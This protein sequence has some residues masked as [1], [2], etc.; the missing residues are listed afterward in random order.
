MKDLGQHF[1][2]KQ[3]IA[4]KIVQSINPS[5]DDIVL[6]IGGGKGILTEQIVDKV[7]KL[8]V[9]EIDKNLCKF[10][11]DK[12]KNNNNVEIINEDF[13]EVDL[14]RYSLY[15]KLKIV[16][17]IP[18]S[19]TSEILYKLYGNTN[20]WQVC[21]LMLQYEVARKLVAVPSTAEFSQLTLITNFYT[22]VNLLFKV[23]KKYFRP[24]P[25][26]GSCVV[27]FIPNDEFNEFQDKEK[28]FWLVSAAFKHKRKFL[29]NSLS[30][31]L[32]IDKESLK[33][34]VTNLGIKSTARPQDLSLV[35]YI[36]LLEKLN[37]FIPI[38][39][40]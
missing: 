20:F 2:V 16:G 7:R 5:K 10:L 25:K 28:L 19:I 22:K 6:E 4:K 13:L 36:K 27:K 35:Q 26:V 34:I 14:Q 32:N 38:S 1:L 23:G 30:Y 8:F 39:T 37:K 9:V 24:E 31:E 15:G 11:S 33:K 17:N 18:Y 3:N 21:V 12:F 29:V 40:T